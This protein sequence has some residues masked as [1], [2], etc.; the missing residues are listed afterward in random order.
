[1]STQ[2]SGWANYETWS[3]RLW[4]DND[5]G[6]QELHNEMT[7]EVTEGE[8][9]RRDA[10]CELACRFQDFWEERRPELTDVWNDLLVTSFQAID[11]REIAMTFISAVEEE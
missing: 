1:M 9:D 10:V 2:Y 7:E 6:L 5:Q 3:M 8:I 4:I 11:W